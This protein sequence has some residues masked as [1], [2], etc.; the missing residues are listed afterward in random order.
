MT[1]TPEAIETIK[2]LASHLKNIAK[3]SEDTLLEHSKGQF[4]RLLC[5]IHW[6]EKGFHSTMVSGGPIERWARL[7]NHADLQA[8]KFEN[9][10]GADIE[11]LVADILTMSKLPHLRTFAVEIYEPDAKGRTRM[12]VE[13]NQYPVRDKNCGPVAMAKSLYESVT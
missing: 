1:E 4:D 9:D 8:V 10:R 11:A 5:R 6:A 3:I 12:Q 13:I 7:S 2:L